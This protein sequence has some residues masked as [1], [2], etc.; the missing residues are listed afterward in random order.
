M[1]DF[2]ADVAATDATIL[3][4]CNATDPA[5]VA[6]SANILSLLGAANYAAATALLFSSTVV[7]S[8]AVN[9]TFNATTGTKIGTA[10]TEKLAF[11]N[12]TPI[13]QPA[14]T[15][16]YVTMLVN[17]GLRASGGTAGATFPGAL[18][19]TA[20]TSTS[21]AATGDIAATGHITMTDAKNIVI[22][23]TTGT[24]IGTG[25][26]QKIGFWNVTPIVQPANTVDYVT[27]LTDL[28]LRAT[29]GTA[30]A[31][32]P[33]ALSCTALTSTSIA[34][35]GDIAATGHITMTDAKN[36]VINATTGT[37]IGTGT[38]QKISFW[39][40]TPI[41]QPANTVDYVTMLTD[42]GLRATGGTAA[43]TFPGNVSCLALTSTSIAATGTV[44]L[45]DHMTIT[46][47]KNIV[48]STG[49]GTKIGTGVTQ[50]LGFWNATPVVQPVGATQAAPSAYITGAFG[51]DSDV[52]MQALYDLVVA[53]RTALV[54]TGI[55]K[56]AA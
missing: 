52:K 20:L 11:W 14:N 37:K 8:D 42:L 7:F 18:S 23:A 19:C 12:A 40:A 1:A 54:N 25:A 44:A 2:P 24:K 48:L 3:L 36:I 30:G 55:I 28:G 38:T 43:A 6:I 33:G 47:V 10:T 49:T 45:T 5:K 53:M 27:M 51:L 16:D 9:L 13:V 31:T 50:K 39:N 15:V 17:L 56:G 32:F 34:A 29:G 46:D 22:N 21:I 41:V 26:T 35:T 4:G